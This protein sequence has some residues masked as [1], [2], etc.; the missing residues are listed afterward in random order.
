MTNSEHLLENAIMCLEN[1]VDF[2]EF[3]N[4]DINKTMSTYANIALEQIWEMAQYVVYNLKPYW[5]ED[6][7]I[8]KKEKL[9]RFAEE[10]EEERHQMSLS[11]FERGRWKDE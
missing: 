2:E 1:K 5:L 9:A 8:S 4:R 10:L 11:M 7:Q 6:V 3:A